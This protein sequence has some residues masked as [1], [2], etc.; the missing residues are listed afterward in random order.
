MTALND[1][2]VG[3]ASRA[4]ALGVLLGVERG[5]RSDRL[6]DGALCTSR[7]EARDRRLAT[8]IVYGTLRRQAT[9]D[10]TLA[11]FCD[12]SFERLEPLVRC[13]L[14]LAAYQCAFL[15][16]VP[17]RAAVFASVEVVKERRPRAAGL[18]NGVLRAWLRAG[19]MLDEGDGSLASRLD[20]PPW[21]AQRWLNRYGEAATEVWWRAALEPAPRALRVHPRVL[22]T[23]AALALLSEAGVVAQRSP[24]TDQCVRVLGSLA[25][26]DAVRQG[27]ITPRSEASQLVT[28]LLP[29]GPGWTVDACAGRGG[30]SVQL[31]EAGAPRVLALDID[32]AQLADARAAAAGA[33][34]PEVQI[35]CADLTGEFPVRG[36]FDRILVDAPCSGLGT[37]RRHPEIKWRLDASRLDN[38]ARRQSQLLSRAVEAL[39][40]GG[41]ILYVTCSTEP[42][43]NDAV[44]KAVTCLYHDVQVEHLEFD[45]VTDA[46]GVDG[47]FRTYPVAPELDG[48]FAALLRRA[49]EG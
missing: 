19:A 8:E 46:I 24:A 29:P 1:E 26:C 37:V 44:I 16:S 33:A 34:T 10:R 2:A 39:A 30:K 28:G 38:L 40:P 25:A 36:R 15:K 31:A 14:R 3:V 11:R 27:L 22:S 47:Y 43:E 18:V 12:Q 5:G 9:L 7:L 48:F 45:S 21:L 35:A 6:L 49:P 23:T 4:L 13:T 17:A 20:V 42:E 41:L 32:K